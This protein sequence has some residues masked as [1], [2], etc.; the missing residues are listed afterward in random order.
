VC[1]LNSSGEISVH[2]ATNMKMTVFWDV[3]VRAAYLLIAL[4]I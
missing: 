1:G 3:A 2:T 4:M